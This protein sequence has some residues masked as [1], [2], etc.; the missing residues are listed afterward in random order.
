MAKRMRR[1]VALIAVPVVIG[2]AGPVQSASA[3]DHQIGSGVTTATNGQG[4]S[5]GWAAQI[6]GTGKFKHIG[7][8]TWHQEISSGSCGFGPCDAYADFTF[9]AEDGSTLTGSAYVEGTSETPR[10]I[11]V[12][13][14]GSLVGWT[15]H[16]SFSPGASDSGFIFT[17]EINRPGRRPGH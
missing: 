16:V 8:G 17:G 3:K 7:K 12:T 1:A 2:L 4:G 6:D 11:D 15:G 13:G 14:T 9:F 10:V 5:G